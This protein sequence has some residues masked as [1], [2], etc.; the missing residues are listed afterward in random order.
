MVQQ[1]QYKTS[2]FLHGTF[3]QVFKKGVFLRGESS[4]GKSSLAFALVKRGHLF[5]ADDLVKIIK[6]EGE[7]IGS[8]VNSEK[9]IE[10]R[11][12]GIFDLS[13]LF[14][15]DAILESHKIDIIVDLSKNE[16]KKATILGV[17]F[18]PYFID[19][20]CEKEKVS[21]VEKLALLK[22]EELLVK[23][24]NNNKRKKVENTKDCIC[25]K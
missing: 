3:L 2:I 20:S 7:L 19:F 4:S 11:P 24:N 18:T 15:K 14:G 16:K 17:S 25:E 13:N 5:I 6:K 8:S 22:D 21:Y 9:L 23:D 12:Y 10:I 1:K